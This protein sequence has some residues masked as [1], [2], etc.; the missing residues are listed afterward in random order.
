MT[1]PYTGNKDLSTGARPGTRRL[2]DWILF[3]N[4][5][6]KNLGIYSNRNVRGGQTKSVHATGR[7]FD[8]GAP[9]EALAQIIESIYRVRDE[10]HIEE[11]HDYIGAWIPDQGF[12]AGYRCDR[13]TGG[14]L[15]GW[16]IYT[17]NTIGRGGS[18]TH[19]ELA[20]DYADDPDLVDQAITRILEAASKE[21]ASENPSDPSTP[22]DD[23][24]PVKKSSSRVRARTTSNP[25]D[26]GS[27]L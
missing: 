4:P 17:R 11:I 26:T 18:W 6:A 13:D 19:I 24:V 10:L 14:I 7:A 23:S 12:G 1:R 25:S 21:T 8:I 15:S 20:P 3:F 9:R 22:G 2:V 27:S 5:D 16:R